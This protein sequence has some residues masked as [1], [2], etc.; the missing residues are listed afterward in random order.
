MKIM[1]ALACAFVAVLTM[2]AVQA[3]ELA[4]PTT[5]NVGDLLAPWMQ[6]LVGAVAVVI[7]AILG[8]IAAQ[9]KAKTGI[10]IE[11]RH[12]EALQTALTNAAGLV[13]NKLGSKI[14]DMTFDV[15]HQ[16]IREAVMYVS[17]AVPD[18]V[19]NFDLSPEQLAEKLV[20]KLG[21]ATAPQQLPDPASS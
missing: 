10:D 3:Q 16:A 5:I 1:F 2:G 19:K 8:W 7:T 4:P 6:M 14:S 13:L 11:A 20:A 9:I 18:A 12:R 17:E 15:R 21:L